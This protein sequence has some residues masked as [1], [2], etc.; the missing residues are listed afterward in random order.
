MEFLLLLK[1]AGIKVSHKSYEVK[2]LCHAKELK[3]GCEIL[4][5]MFYCWNYILKQKWM[6]CDT[7]EKGHIIFVTN[8]I[9]WL[10]NLIPVQEKSSK[11]PI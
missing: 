8:A 10:L 7:V 4:L 1:K 11:T 2:I 6:V 3:K 5:Q 9:R